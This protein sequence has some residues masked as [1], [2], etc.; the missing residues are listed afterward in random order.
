M[1]AA[2]VRANAVVEATTGAKGAKVAEEAEVEAEEANSSSSPQ[3]EDP[4]TTQTH[5]KAVA[6]AIISG[7]R[8]VGTASHPSHVLGST[9]L[10]L[11][12]E[13]PTSLE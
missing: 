1:A 10:R 7:A 3:T 6:T 11:G 8:I 9:R 12:H 13:G 2:G 5:P 4:A